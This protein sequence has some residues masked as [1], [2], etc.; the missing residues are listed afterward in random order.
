MK[1][2]KIVAGITVPIAMTFLWIFLYNSDL[3]GSRQSESNNS[4]PVGKNSSKNTQDN[5]KKQKSKADA[6]QNNLSGKSGALDSDLDDI[7]TPASERFEKAIARDFAKHKIIPAEKCSDET[8]CRRV[9]IDLIG[10]LPTAE[11]AQKF[12][13]DKSSDKREKLINELLNRKEFAWYWSLKWCD[14]LRVKSEFPIKLWPNAVACY[15]T[16]ITHAIEANM[17]YDKFARALLTTS[18]SNF[19]KPPVNF[20]RAIQQKTP[21]G[22]SNAVTLTFMGTSLKYFPKETQTKIIEFFSR[23]KY[24]STVEW[25]EEI[26]INNPAPINDATLTLPDN[27]KVSAGAFDDRRILFAN[28]LINKKN[29]WFAKA[30]VNRI[31]FWVFGRGLL[32]PPNNSTLRNPPI[33]SRVLKFLEKEFIRSGYDQKYIIKLIVNCSIYQQSWQPKDTPARAKHF[34]AAYPIRRLDAEV[35]IDAIN[36]LTGST[37]KYYSIVPEPFTF[38]P[39]SNRTIQLQDGT[40]TSEF[41]NMFGRPSRDTGLLTERNNKPSISQQLFMLNST[42]LATKIQKSEK[43]KQLVRNRTRDVDSQIEKIF[44]TILSR[45]PNVKELKK[46]KKY[47]SQNGRRRARRNALIDIIWALMNTKEFLYRH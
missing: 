9:F 42:T 1:K 10:T 28:W 37:E 45:K 33:H 29:P 12:L 11:E 39:E 24:K 6:L 23:V 44:L 7:S 25:K 46:I 21:V 31:W 15:S 41:L 35:L 38:I 4:L 8:F 36:Q 34:F 3:F 47:L 26:V 14:H 5:S 13:D 22:I 30:A 16:W 27:S 20:Y 17:P 2:L 18:G 19:R 43:I 40:I 32:N